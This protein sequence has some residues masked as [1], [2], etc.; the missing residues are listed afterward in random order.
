M[1]IR[2]YNSDDY[3]VCKRIIKDST[4]Q[5]NEEYSDE[6]LEHLEEVI[7]DMVAGFAEKE[8]FNFYVA[9]RNDEV[10]GVAGYHS[11]GEIAG[12]FI[13]PDHQREGIG[14]KLMKELE[15]KASEEDI[16]KL[17]VSSSLTAEKFYEKLGFQKIKK[18]DSDIEG[19]DIP[20]YKMEKEL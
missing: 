6:E 16:Q 20:V 1:R 11:K 5:I 2:E 15:R 17:E 12:V 8:G 4:S 7:P 13:H 3:E 10:M 19:K 14:E 9:E 18:K